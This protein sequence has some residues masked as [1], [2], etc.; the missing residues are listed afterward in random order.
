MPE[1]KQPGI[2]FER[3]ILEKVNLETNPSFIMKDEGLSVDM[4]VKVYRNLNKS[5]NRLK[6]SLDVRLFEKAKNP[7]LRIS[8][9]ATGYFSA[10]KREDFSLEKFSL[11]QAPAL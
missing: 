11:V 4:T 9:L 10:K 5:K 2:D 6:L 8:I 7:P 1:G 3:V